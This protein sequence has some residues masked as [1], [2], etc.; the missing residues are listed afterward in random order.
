M[1]STTENIH[2]HGRHDDDQDDFNIKEVVMKYVKHWP[3]IAGTVII[4]LGLAYFA[5]KF[6]PPRYLIESKFLIKEEESILNIFDA[7]ELTTNGVLPKG[8]KVA[9]ETILMKSRAIA[10]R[11]LD[12][13]NFDVEYYQK[14]AF[15]YSEL[16]SN[17][18]VKVEVDW[19]HMQYTNGMIQ[20]TW[21]NNRTFQINYVDSKYSQIIPSDERSYEVTK[22]DLTKKTFAF[23]EWVELPFTRFRVQALNADAP[24]TLFIK[25]RDKESLLKQYTGDNIQVTSADKLSSI[26]SLT[27]ETEQPQKGRDYLNALMRVFL[28]KELEEKNS[29][30]RNTIN[31]IDTQLLGI[32]DSLSQSQSRL[33]NFRSTNR[34]NDLSLE[35]NTIYEELARLEQTRAEE[36]FKK[37]YYLGLQDYMTQEVY[38]EVVI[39]SGLGIED[40]VLNNLITQLV[41]LQSEKS[42]LLASQTENSPTVV[43]VTRKIKGLNASIKEVLANVIRNSDL[44]LSDLNKRIGRIEAQFGKLPK[45]EQELLNI[46]RSYSLNENIY[47]FLIQRRAEAAILL[48]SNKPSNKISEGAVLTFEPMKLKPMLNYF[49]AIMLG[50]IFPIAGIFVYDLFAVKIK[51]VKEVEQ[52][53][54][55]PFLGA[56]GQNKHQSPLVVLDQPRSS[57]TESFRALRTNVN[58]LYP[59]DKPVTIMVTS[60]IAGEGKTFCAMNLSAVYSIGNK[61]TI[62]VGCDMRK[63]F[64]FKDL[65]IENTNGLSTYLSEQNNDLSSMIQ[66]TG[67]SNFDVLAPG[68]IPPNPA[69]LL[70]SDRFERMLS[71]LKQKYDVII[72]DS[73][74][75]GITNETLYLTRIADITI[76]VLRQNLSE[77]TFVDE[78][79]ELRVK[80]GIKNI[81][82]ILNDVHEKYLRHRGYGYGYYEEDGSKTRKAKKQ[83]VS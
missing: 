36:N 10:Q 60:S 35:T 46:K 40:P 63:V 16:Y 43:E 19:S 45:T 33:Q 6:T 2:S 30:A 7:G 73:S 18:P 59:K 52:K 74:P 50:F 34:T 14:G 13:L 41:E 48:A 76:Y 81:Y 26:L 61:K 56:I 54:R 51:E 8:Q 11:T 38:T 4:A 15:T 66:S 79:N 72:L 31:F 29:I 37:S 44:I 67:T 64:N 57:I 65:S 28:D 77:K 25:L 78:I 12:Q 53:L 80:K 47:T 9:N 58:F 20:I 5:N 17:I 39:P 3:I 71:E 27:L 24:G 75:L 22:P 42:R 68:P 83:T 69:E 23:N 82:V 49:L 21:A 1:K 32:T 70:I 62:L 55:V